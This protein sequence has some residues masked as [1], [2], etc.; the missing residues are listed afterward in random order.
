MKRILG[1]RLI[2]YA[3]ATVLVGVTIVYLAT[4]YGYSAQSRL[5]PVPIAWLM[6]ALL[7]LDIV[8]RTET[9]VGRSLTRVLNP[10]AAE[11][12][13]EAEA[14]QSAMRQASALIWV[15]LF[16]AALVLIGILYA[17]PLYIFGSMR[18]HGKQ[19]YFTSLV[20]AAVMTVFTWAMFALALQIEL[21]PGLL[22]GVP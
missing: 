18:F 19:T 2:D 22:F 4:A 5:F 14:P 9:P 20:T 15:M 1:T 7:A 21:Y 16:T 6:L 12:S 17:V 8:S 3:P 13:A 11:K 10:A